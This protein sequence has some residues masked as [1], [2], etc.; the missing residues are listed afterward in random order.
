MSRNGRLNADARRSQ[1]QGQII[2]ERR[3]LAD[4]YART[5][6]ARLD[7]ER[8]HA[9][10]RDRRPAADLNDLCRRAEGC[11]CF[12]QSNVRVD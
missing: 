8:L 1:R 6:A 11:Q 3:D 2:G 7:E 10:L 5:P 4:A 9:K 12:L